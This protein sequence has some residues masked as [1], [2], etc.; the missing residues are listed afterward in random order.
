MTDRLKNKLIV[1]VQAQGNEPLNKPEYLLAMSQSV[2]N[3]GAGALR[4]CGIDN[5]K[6]I[7][8]NVSVPVIGLTKLEPTP[9]NW[10][11]KVYITATLKD[12]KELLK[13]GIEFIAIDG[14]N[15][16]REDDSSLKDQIS[17]IKEEGRSI[18]ADV[19]TFEEGIYASE[20]GAD[21]IS[22]TLSGYT[23]ET[24]YKANN[25]PDFELL[26]ELTEEISTPVILEGRI[27]ELEDVKEAF[28][29]GAHAVVIGT[30]I[31]RPQIITKRFITSLPHN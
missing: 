27:W 13:T 24:R 28:K 25:G 21:I 19:S 14:T 6:H 20:L 1:S 17:L 30:A 4:L 7:K 3:G 29:I 5:I 18:I 9:I 23:K 8:K 26:S 22:T 31:T 15:R 10:L 12:L 11:D 16:K 2:I